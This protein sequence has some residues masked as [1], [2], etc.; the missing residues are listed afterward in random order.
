MSVIFWLVRIMKS[1]LA[2]ISPC[3]YRNHGCTH[4][5][6]FDAKEK[7]QSDV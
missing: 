1:T 3:L 4:W 2:T 7:S 5:V 6:T